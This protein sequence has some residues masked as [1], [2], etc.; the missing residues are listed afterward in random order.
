MRAE[1]SIRIDAVTISAL[2]Q[3][4]GRLAEVF[5]TLGEMSG[6]DAQALGHPEVARAVEELLGNWTLMR[7][8]LAQ[9]L[10]D[11]GAAAQ[12]AG[13]VYLMTETDIVRSLGCTPQVCPGAEVPW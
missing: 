4:L 9:A 10:D 2:G 5:A 6:A 11:L 13:A 3:D 7:R 1:A 12:Q 8:D